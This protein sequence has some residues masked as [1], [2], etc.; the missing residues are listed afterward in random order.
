MTSQWQ[1]AQARAAIASAN[2]ETFYRDGVRVLK[3]DPWGSLE[4]CMAAMARKA[5]TPKFRA[6]RVG[7][8]EE[9]RELLGGQLL[10]LPVELTHRRTESNATTNKIPSTTGEEQNGGA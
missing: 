6:V 8:T 3:H 2:P 10:S 9:G 1:H 4:R 5:R 7:I